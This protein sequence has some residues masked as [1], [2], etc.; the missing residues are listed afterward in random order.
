M[1][2]TSNL[3]K[4]EIM[5]VDLSKDIEH[6]LYQINNNLCL[7]IEMLSSNDEINVS[8][9]RADIQRLIEEN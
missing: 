1:C 5:T 9:T 8:H 6:K 3:L 2:A 4:E 7:L